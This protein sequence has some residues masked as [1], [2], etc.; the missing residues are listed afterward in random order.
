MSELEKQLVILEKELNRHMN[1]D[2]PSMSVCVNSADYDKQRGLK[3]QILCNKQDQIIGV[4][5]LIIQELKHS[6][7]HLGYEILERE[8]Q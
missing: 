8:E 4:M 1:D 3:L 6:N 7:L 2:W 5:K